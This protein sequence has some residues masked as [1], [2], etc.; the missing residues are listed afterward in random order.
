MS[1]IIRPLTPEDAQLFADYMGSDLFAHSPN[2]SGCY[3]RFY[4]TTYDM[5][6]WIARNPLDNRQEALE[7]IRSGTMKGYLAFDGDLCVGWCNA[8][9]L[10]AYPRMKAFWPLDL[11][12]E[13]CGA[14]LCTVIHPDYRGQGLARRM[15]KAAVEGF[16]EAVFKSVL[17]FPVKS[18]AEPQKNYRGT[19]NMFL[20]LGYQDLGLMEGTR[21][22]RLDF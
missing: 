18:E 13:T 3:C 2:W 19:P 1:T 15:L 21:V 12:P 20:E 14:T 4:Q 7:A 6:T 5:E 11:D 22:F 10:S 9:R 16:H 8:N 17:A